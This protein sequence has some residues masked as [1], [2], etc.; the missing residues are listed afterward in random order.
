MSFFLFGASV[1][2]LLL[3]FVP[4][5]K[6]VKN[7]AVRGI[8]LY[9]RTIQ[10]FEF[11]KIGIILYLAKAIEYWQDSLNTFRD[12]A[13]KLLLP[14]LAVCGIIVV[15]SFS[16]AILIGTIGFLLMFFMQVKL[17]YLLISLGGIFA[18]ILLMFG[19][20]NAFYKNST[21]PESEKG[22]I[23][24]FFNRFGTV[25]NRVA[26]FA[27]DINDK[28]EEEKIASMS[29]FE[30]KEYIDEIRQSEN[31]KIAISEG[32]II[33][34][35]PGK[36]TQRYSL[37]MA[38]SDF[39][40]AFIVE[41]YGLAGGTIVILLYIMFLFRSIRISYKCQTLYSCS[42]V[43]GLSFL[44]VLQAFMHIFVNVRLMPIT[45]H[46][47]PLISHGGTAYMVLC[48]AFGII[49][50][51]S[52]QVDKQEQLEAAQAQVEATQTEQ[53]NNDFN[54]EENYNG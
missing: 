37:S 47:L 33:G 17:R 52:K 7:G 15:N 28:T 4:G 35:G 25:Q 14:I 5:I 45:G 54:K 43:L 38:Y 23:E 44:I 19:I 36:S 1:V 11:A 51:V 26:S 29:D 53:I 50:S 42:V 27:S 48:G 21:T 2:L 34:K 39:I 10:V 20:Y 30:K 41:E 8:K 46:T 6:D 9:G 32:G 31:A 49:L 18:C 12:F 40:Y 16:S 24:K 22:V 3:L 13:V